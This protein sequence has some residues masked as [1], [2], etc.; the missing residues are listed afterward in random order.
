MVIEQ[1]QTPADGLDEDG[2]L[3]TLSEWSRSMA[4]ELAE[5]NDI[6]PLTEGHWKII[7][8]VKTCNEHQC[9]MCFNVGIYQ[10]GTIAPDSVNQLKRLKVGV[11][12]G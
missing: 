4:E 1:T 11:K 9:P 8:F 7:E 5:K 2:F 12:N 3:Q 6:G 10:D